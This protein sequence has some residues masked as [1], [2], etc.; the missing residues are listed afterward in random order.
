MEISLNPIGYFHCPQKAAYQSP[1]QGHLQDNCGTVRLNSGFNFEQALQNLEG[2]SHI[3]LIYLFH[4]NHNW[5]PLVQTPRS[6]TKIG[7]FATR[8][9]HRP[10]PI[11]MSCVKLLTIKGLDLEVQHHDLLD[12][13]PILDIKPYLAESDL[14]SDSH[15]PWIQE[16]GP[17]FKLQYSELFEQQLAWLQMQIHRDSYLA[18]IGQFLENQLHYDPLNSKKKRLALHPL[19]Y[20][21]A[22]RTWR[23][24]FTPPTMNTIHLSHI[25]SGY[26]ASDLE[27]PQDK[28]LDKEIHKEFRK[29]FSQI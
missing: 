24:V 19:G 4:H 23:L 25:E 13:T 29:L 28:Y 3:W 7:I 16:L 27:E 1:R 17:A 15:L 22:Y 11:G 21:L 6:T 20:S 10:N 9:P 2:V 8:S 18:T 14:I 12:G 5:K 26:S